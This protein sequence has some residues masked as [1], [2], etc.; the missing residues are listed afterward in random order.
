[1]KLKI[2]AV[3]D[4]ATVDE[5][6]KKLNILGIFS[7]IFAREFPARHRRL[8]IV[9]KIAAEL[10]DTADERRLTITLCDDDK[11]ELVQFEASFSIPHGASGIRPDFNAVWEINLLE[12]PHDGH[13][14]I[15][16]E[17]D[18]AELGTTSLELIHIK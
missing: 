3:A 15:S 1:M 13:Y 17:V 7:T 2:L 14:Q 18:N 6:T 16:V 10:S 11:V 4:Y 5:I 9:A 8:V 12:F